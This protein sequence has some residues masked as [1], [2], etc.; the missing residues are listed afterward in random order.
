VADP[1][2]VLA[3]RDVPVARTYSDVEI[4]RAVALVNAFGT[5]EVA[6]RDGNAAQALGVERGARVTVRPARRVV[7]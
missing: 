3:G 4:G 2:V 5:V 7:L 1:V 6:V